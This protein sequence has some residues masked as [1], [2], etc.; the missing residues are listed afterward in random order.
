MSSSE[1]ISSKLPR[2]DDV[3][4]ASLKEEVEK[5]KEALTWSFKKRE[6]SAT[7]RRQ[8]SCVLVSFCV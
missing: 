2:S 8:V 7:K 1:I 5:E 6:E 3:M 4:M